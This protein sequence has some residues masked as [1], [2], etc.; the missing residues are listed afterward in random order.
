MFF[1]DKDEN[2]EKSRTSIMIRPEKLNKDKT[3]EMKCMT[4]NELF[5]QLQ[6]EYANDLA[7]S[8]LMHKYKLTSP[9]LKFLDL[10]KADMSVIHPSF[11][12]KL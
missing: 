9:G 1:Q 4:Y 6:Q 2:E 5:D 7:H 10:Q 11:R 12:D 3:G 8:V